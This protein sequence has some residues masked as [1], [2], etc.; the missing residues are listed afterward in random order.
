MEGGGFVGIGA[1]DGNIE[2]L[3]YDLPRESAECL[4]M[5]AV[6]ALAE[7]ILTPNPGV[8][9]PAVTIRFDITKHDMRKGRKTGWPVSGPQ[10]AGASLSSN[11]GSSYLDVVLNQLSFSPAISRVS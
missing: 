1:V 3:V 5:L 11:G 6:A 8:S 9:M 10:S 4:A 7:C 2:R